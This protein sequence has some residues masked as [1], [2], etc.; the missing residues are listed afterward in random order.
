MSKRHTCCTFDLDALECNISMDYLVAPICQ[1]ENGHTAFSRCCFKLTPLRICPTCQLMTGVIHNLQLEKLNE[2]L[3]VACKYAE[4][5]CRKRPRLTAE[6]AH[7]ISCGYKSFKCPASVGCILM[8]SVSGISHHFQV[9]HAVK[10]VE[11]PSNEWV[12]IV[13]ELTVN[14]ADLLLKTENMLFLFHHEK[15]LYGHVIY[16]LSFAEAS[17]EN[18]YRYHVEVHLGETVFSM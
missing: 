3:H 5:G 8:C 7:E 17:Q 18:A 16:I 2:T 12:E 1:C 4:F 6:I 11:V 9:K 14:S 15:Q 13:L 10:M